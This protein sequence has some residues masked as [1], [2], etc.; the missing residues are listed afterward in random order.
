MTIAQDVKELHPFLDG[1]PKCMLIGG[2]WES[3]ASGMT[4]LTVNPSTAQGIAELASGD[5][6]DVD[7]AVRA[8]R[9]AFEGPWGR[10]T[11][12]QR[13]DVLLRLAD[14]LDH[15]FEDLRLL[16]VIDMGVPAGPSLRTALSKAVE[17]V[18]YYAGWPTKIVG[19]TI[20]GP[21]GGV[22]CYTLREP[23]GVVAAILPW[24][25]PFLSG[26]QKLAPALAAGCTVVLKPSELAALSV[27]RLG[28]VIEELGLP[29]GVVNIVTGPGPVV[30]A[31][32]AS[33]PDVD[34]ISFTG[35]TAT[36]QSIVRAAAGN[37]KRLSLEL[38]G[39][40]P[41][42]VFADADL[43]A[44]VSAAA[45]GVFR[46]AGQMC[47]ATSRVFVQEAIHDE[48]VERLSAVANGLRVGNS[49]DPATDVGPLISERQ[50]GR[51]AGYVAGARSD[52]ALAVA[53]GDR[54]TGGPYGD[55]YFIS[56]TVFTDVGDDM[57]IAREEVFGPVVAVMR[58]SDAEEAVRRANATPY[59][60]A[61]AVWTSKVDTALTMASAL[62]AG[63]VWVNGFALGD[64]AVPF[65]GF[66]M[67][68]WGNERGKESLDEFL[69]VKSVF[70]A[71]SG[72]PG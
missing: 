8:A 57:T 61:A 9:E 45:E 53:G 46:Q 49:L 23:V 13:E 59:G 16:D 64:P 4:F 15:R 33:H 6:E 68:G 65:G 22:F 50:L 32:L 48:F 55:G 38:G 24:N 51:V 19:E 37:L 54:L 26:L 44:A 3:A 69:N 12:S 42:V 18:R 70:V 41:N 21:G 29:P 11:A 1:Q 10:F 60:L 35:S 52:G 14:L 71:P 67:S 62:Q 47:I 72:P 34:K 58:F 28:E 5:A 27:L 20:P 40:S 31:A 39:K 25:G 36:G 43:D 63:V 56:P 17:L 30:G 66:K 7:R 2:E